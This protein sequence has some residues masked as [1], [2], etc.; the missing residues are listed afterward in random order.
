MLLGDAPL[1][2]DES[3]CHAEHQALNDNRLMVIQ[4][5][6]LMTHVSVHQSVLTT[7]GSL[8]QA[9]GDGRIPKA[10]TQRVYSEQGRRCQHY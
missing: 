2:N 3:P 1:M 8:C 4:S 7:H 10:T 5:I 9:R 6:Q